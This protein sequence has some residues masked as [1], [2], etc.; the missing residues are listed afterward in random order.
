MTQAIG[1][2]KVIWLYSLRTRETVSI[3]SPLFI[4]RSSRNPFG[5]RRRRPPVQPVAKIAAGLRWTI[6]AR[7][8][9]RHQ[10]TSRRRATNCT[11]HVLLDNAAAT[12]QH[13]RAVACP[14]DGNNVEPRPSRT[15][16]CIIT[17]S[18]PRTTYGA[19]DVP[20]GL[21]SPSQY[22]AQ[23][24][25]T[26]PPLSPALTPWLQR[27]TAMP[28]THLM[29]AD[30]P[31]LCMLTHSGPPSQTGPRPGPEQTC[32]RGVRLELFSEDRELYERMEDAASRG[33]VERRRDKAVGSPSGW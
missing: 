3:R 12:C 1:A 31:Q 32:M 10:A 16:L 26:P 2:A 17:P 19:L 5:I 33:K 6:G 15:T 21:D 22:R 20:A 7:R 13:K 18:D 23:R 25:A 4:S 24:E 11:T 27:S 14:A 9:D 8:S 30:S 28:R 29:P